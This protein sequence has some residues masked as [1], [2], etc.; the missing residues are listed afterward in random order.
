MEKRPFI[1]TYER[2]AAVVLEARIERGFTQEELAV[3][4]GVEPEFVADL[5]NAVPRGEIGSL[6]DVMDALEI[7]FR[8]LPVM[9]EWA[10]GDDGHLLPKFVS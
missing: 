9:P 10:F 8:A 1:H 6:I 2:L 4:A 5:E 3:L 7:E